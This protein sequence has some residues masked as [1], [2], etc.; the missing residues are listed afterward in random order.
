VWSPAPAG[1]PDRFACVAVRQGRN[2]SVSNRWRWLVVL[3]V[4]VGVAWPVG[5]VMVGRHLWQVHRSGPPLPAVAGVLPTLDHAVAEVAVAVGDD[6]AVAVAGLTPAKAC[7]V[8]GRDGS[9]YTR[10]LDIYLSR[11]GED[12]LITAIAG[13]LPDGYRPR[14]DPAVAG[15]ARPLSADPGP[16]VRLMVRQLGEG[17][18]TATA[19]SD[20]RATNA[21]PSQPPPSPD[22]TVSGT[23]GGI[24][25]RLHSR[26]V[27]WNRRQLACPTGTLATMV[28]ISAPTDSDNLPAR[29]AEA[30]PA[31]ARQYTGSAD[32]L[33]YREGSTSVVVAPTDDGTAVT[34]RYTTGC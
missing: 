22:P 5:A 19:Q 10:K 30:V 27:Q 15:A 24:L 9:I 26:A 20:C 6:A 33:T 25:T 14:R 34:V 18:L 11:G 32:R 17:W 28:A 1:D 12:G 7:H 8:D 4:V 23:V 13:H 31:N 29:L 2:R 16:G 3:V 21:Q